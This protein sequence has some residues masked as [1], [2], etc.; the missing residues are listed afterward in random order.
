MDLSQ[1]EQEKGK[2]L[3]ERRRRKQSERKKSDSGRVTIDQRDKGSVF[4][5]HASSLERSSIHVRLKG[6][7]HDALQLF[8]CLPTACVV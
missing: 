2:E 3:D 8:D 1:D 5:N 4:R 6:W 7:N